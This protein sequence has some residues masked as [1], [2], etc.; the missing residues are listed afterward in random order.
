MKSISFL[1][2]GMSLVSNHMKVVEQ[3]QLVFL[4][5]FQEEIN[6]DYKKG[7]VFLQI[8]PI[9]R[10]EIFLRRNEVIGLINDRLEPFNVRVT[11][12]V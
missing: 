7:K 4:E 2:E 6:I 8:S 12:V 5:M 10:S 11:K 9:L 3:I 1:L